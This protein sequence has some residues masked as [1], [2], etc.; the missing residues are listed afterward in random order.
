MDEVI[1]EKKNK[2]N[3]KENS[4]NNDKNKDNNNSNTKKRKP[5]NKNYS[6]AKIKEFE[7]NSKYFL[8]NINNGYFSERNNRKNRNIFFTYE[9]I[10][11]FD[12]IIKKENEND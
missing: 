7:K 10:K 2:N 5:Y 6:E 8:K 3:P 12:D 11:K 4:N 1:K 9:T